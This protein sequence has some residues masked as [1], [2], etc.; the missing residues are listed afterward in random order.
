MSSAIK[1]LCGM[2]CAFAIVWTAPATADEVSEL[3]QLRREV[4]ALRDEVAQLRKERDALRGELKKSRPTK[5]DR[6]EGELNGI[7]WEISA[8]NNKG[9]AVVAATF[10]AQEGKIMKDGK[11][12]GSY[13]DAGNRARM[14]I[15]AAPSDKA[16]G[17]YSLLRVKNDPPTYSGTFK[18]RTDWK[19]RSCCAP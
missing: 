18:T 1:L 6:P 13:T 9:I 8:I 4:A 3:E 17:T 7:Q 10:Y 2:L 14:D 12:I 16:N 5:E 19:Y 11:A 15:T